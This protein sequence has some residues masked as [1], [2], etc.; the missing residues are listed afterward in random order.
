MRNSAIVVARRKAS[1]AEDARDHRIGHGVVGFSEN[2]AVVRMTSLKST[3][4]IL[5]TYAMVNI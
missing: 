5:L 1:V 3:T 4:T 2:A